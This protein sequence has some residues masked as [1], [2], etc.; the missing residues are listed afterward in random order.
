MGRDTA[1]PDGRVVLPWREG[2]MMLT[3]RMAGGATLTLRAS[4]EGGA[5]LELQFSSLAT[6]KISF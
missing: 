4:G 1:E 3:L 2:D 6:V 5:L